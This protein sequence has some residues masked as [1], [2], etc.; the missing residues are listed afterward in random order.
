MNRANILLTQT[1]V[2]V[3]NLFMTNYDRLR[4]ITTNYRY[5][6]GLR[7]TPMWLA[8]VLRPWI[9]LLPDHR[10]TFVRDYT[11]LAILVFC[12]SWIW[13]AGHY[14]RRRYGAVQ[15]KPIR[16]EMIP[17]LIAVF[18]AYLLC[19]LADEKNPPI[20]FGAALWSCILGFQVGSASRLPRAHRIAYA[21]AS[22]S[23]LALALLPLTG[24][25]GAR[26]LL[27]VDHPSGALWIG[28]AMIILGLIDH[29]QLVRLM[30]PPRS[31]HA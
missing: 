5:L 21:L 9:G 20:S 26:Q 1:L 19:S 18:A 16:P 31:A 15:S 10:P 30:S 3:I 13:M 12:A 22:I 24:A 14:Y 28:A 23:M 17:L 25:I 27:S 4:C 11:M 2:D 6:Q 7:Y 8:F 29:F